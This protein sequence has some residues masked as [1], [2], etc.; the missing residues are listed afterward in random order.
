M[1]AELVEANLRFVVKVAVLYEGMGLPL[2]NLIGEENMGMVTAAR[3]S[4]Q[5]LSGQVGAARDFGSPCRPE[6]DRAAVH[7][8]RRWP[9]TEFKAARNL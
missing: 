1:V 5:I 4:L 9:I 3:L 6:P 7:Q 8:R 2:A